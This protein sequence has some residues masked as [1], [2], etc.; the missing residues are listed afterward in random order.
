MLDKID[1]A[2]IIMLNLKQH[3]L[4]IFSTWKYGITMFMA[5]IKK[6]MYN[7]RSHQIHVRY[8]QAVVDEVV[9]A[10]A[11]PQKVTNAALRA[12]LVTCLL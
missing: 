1:R 8:M 3:E 2:K 7:M 6:L 9:F 5:M 4:Q 10:N 12:F 11:D